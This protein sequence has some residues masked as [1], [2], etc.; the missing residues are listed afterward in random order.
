MNEKNNLLTTRKA[1]Q[2]GQKQMMAPT[3]KQIEEP[4][5]S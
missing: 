1:V 5:N 2:R 4:T 3:A